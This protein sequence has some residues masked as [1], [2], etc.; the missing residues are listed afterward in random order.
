MKQHRCVVMLDSS[1]VKDWPPIQMP[2][3]HWAYSLMQS[4]VL[5][6]I[7]AREGPVVSEWTVP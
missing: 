7:T 1:A 3:L 4:G 6:S 5:T 2:G